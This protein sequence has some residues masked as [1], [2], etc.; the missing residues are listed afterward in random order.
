MPIES[1]QFLCP[2]ICQIFK[3]K[4]CIYYSVLHDMCEITWFILYHTCIRY[5]KVILHNRSFIGLHN[6]A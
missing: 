5:G 6:S 2:W 4:E 3:A 1:K